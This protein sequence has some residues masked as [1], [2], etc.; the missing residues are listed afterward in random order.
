MIY[1]H[2]SAVADRA[3]DIIVIGGGIYGVM[4][5]LEAVRRHQ[6][7]LLLENE[8]FGGATSYSSLRIIHGGLRDLQS[9]DLI[10]YWRFGKERRWYLDYFPELVELLPVLVPLYQRGIMRTEIFKMA[11]LLDRLLLPRRDR[12]LTGRECLPFGEVLSAKEVKRHFPEVEEQGL[13]GGALWYDAC[14]PDSQRLLMQVLRAACGKG[15]D[16]LNYMTATELLTEGRH[17]TGVRARD[18]LTGTSYEFNSDIVINAAGPWSR[19][20]AADAHRDISVLGQPSIAWNILF[21]REAPS[22]CA[23]GVAPHAPDGQRYF[24]HPWKGRL[25]IGT[26]HAPR[27][28]VSAK[29]EP[30]S[31]EISAFIRE[32]NLALPG[33]NLQRDDILHVYSGFLPVDRPNSTDLAKRDAWIDHA[34]HGG[35][36]GLFSVRGTKFTASR[37]TAEALLNSIAPQQQELRDYDELLGDARA[38]V[39]GD[40]AICD[41][42]WYPEPED[43]SWK[44]PLREII[45]SEAV[46]HLD[47][48]IMR[49]TSL[50]D[51]PVRA[52]AVA[53]MVAK[54]FD[55][56]KA[57]REAEIER[58]RSHFPRVG[59]A[60][61]HARVKTG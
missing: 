59:R 31:A 57:R 60:P 53:P 1:R 37:H 30:S 7:V 9:L 43:D 33:F 24:V 55:W 27:E 12:D 48:L 21:D 40:R 61:D 29:P 56:D 13:A 42:E 58:V 35:P 11:F 49:R 8:D 17:V 10:R 23:L 2:L 51:N 36:R 39:P 52:C 26:G 5:A 22:N 4:I 19:D 41:Y 3:H 46:V 38:T 16:A 50:G 15:A 44:K 20:F 25:L 45:Q 32:V 18:K 47:D 28:R 54:L 34:E 14:V 6:S